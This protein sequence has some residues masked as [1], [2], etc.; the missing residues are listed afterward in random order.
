MC[1]GD[2]ATR[3]D[4]VLV[5]QAALAA[6]GTIEY[7][8]DCGIKSHP[9]L[10]VSFNI[11]V[12]NAKARFWRTPAPFPIPLSVSDIDLEAM[13]DVWIGRGVFGRTK[14]LTEAGETSES[15]L[16]MSECGARFLAELFEDVNRKGGGFVDC[17]Q[18]HLKRHAS[19]QE[20]KLASLAAE[21]PRTFVLSLLPPSVI[22][23]GP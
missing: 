23:M 18:K 7:D 13:W 12:F 15:W 22:R 6:L 1:V 11:P 3:I 19:G 14:G 9:A 21:C 8:Y 4:V 10:K 20:M 5:N 2:G 16:C 17:P